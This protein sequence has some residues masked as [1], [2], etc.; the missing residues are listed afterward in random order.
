MK[1]TKEISRTVVRYSPFN[2][3]NKTYTGTIT[4]KF[5]GYVRLL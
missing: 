5:N 2:Y 4:F 1:V 3:L